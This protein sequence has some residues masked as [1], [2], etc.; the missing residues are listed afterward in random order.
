MTTP[1]PPIANAF[2]SL[3]RAMAT[4]GMAEQKAQEARTLLA[5]L[6]GHG[7]GPLDGQ[8]PCLCGFDGTMS[9]VGAHIMGEWEKAAK[10]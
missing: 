2:R 10:A 5:E 9:Q 4:I 1:T 3:Q 6:T 7:A 8:G